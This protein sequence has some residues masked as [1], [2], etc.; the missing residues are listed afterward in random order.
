MLKITHLTSVHPRYDTRIFSKMCSSLA[1][2]DDYQVSLIVA[3]GKG[4]ETKNNVHIIDVGAKTAGRISR[5]TKTTK[6]V[7][8]KAKEIDADIYHF[9]D[10]ELIP[11]GVKLK[12]IGKKVIYDIHEDFPRQILSKPY[13]SRLLSKIIS[14]FFEKYENYC[15]KK[16]N[17]L[18]TAT[19][20]IKKRFVNIGCDAI[21]VQNMP[22]L[23]E[24]TNIENIWEKKENAICYIGGIT[25]IRGIF[26]L[27]ETMKLCKKT[28]LYIAGPI[29]DNTIKDKLKEIANINYL[30]IIDRNKIAEVFK[31][32]LCGI[33]TFQPLPNHNNAIPNKM[34]EY[35]S[36][37]LPVIA[38]NFPLWKE[39]IEGNNCGIC[40]DPLNPEEIA[41][42][43]EYLIENPEKAK[44]MGENGKR[45]V[46]G[47]YNWDLE[48][49]KLLKVYKD[50]SER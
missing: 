36:A 47:K 30:G 31:K 26:E 1:K 24:F 44:E 3:D 21:D 43:I 42:A 25:K 39:I 17:Y 8:K 10:P 14:F 23:S 46:L 49:K 28:T 2:N 40:V 13:L 41:K 33:V 18:I 34:F 35:M 12:K 45:A 27:I 19:P 15:A 5:M 11:I 16:F 9:H 4:N 37:G 38:S 20:F 22:I 7:F 48:E 29:E 6:N 50:L 32:T